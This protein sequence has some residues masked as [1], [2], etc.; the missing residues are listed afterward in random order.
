MVIGARGRRRGSG[1]L[2]SRGVRVASLSSIVVLA[3]A[4]DVGAVGE[5][6]AHEEQVPVAFEALPEPPARG[7]VAFRAWAEQVAAVEGAWLGAL[8]TVELDGDPTLERAARLCGDE[9]TYTLLIEDPDSGRRWRVSESASSRAPACPSTEPVAWEHLDEGLSIVD[10]GPGTHLERWLGLREDR[11]VE[12]ARWEAWAGPMLPELE[13][14]WDLASFAGSLEIETDTERRRLEREGWIL[15]VGSPM[16]PATT[17]VRSGTVRWRGNEDASIAARASSM[18]DG[19]VRLEIQVRDDHPIAA[20][21][22]SL[23]D[24]VDSLE[25][26]W[27]SPGDDLRDPLGENGSARG[28]KL[29]PLRDGR[30]HVA[31]IDE[32]GEPLPQVSGELAQLEV[33]LPIGPRVGVPL[34]LSLVFHDVDGRRGTRPTVIATS[35]FL[36][37]RPAT[38]GWLVQHAE[39]GACPPVGAPV[40]PV[41]PTT[42]LVVRLGE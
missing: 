29:V 36:P 24:G 22:A 9:L 18:D 15:T 35:R 4:A 7:D 14:R 26:W 27:A 39:P 1:A 13:M 42:G 20:P 6:V 25:I 19:R 34:P 28:L 41:G 23:V 8:W 5:P 17:Q 33:I 38:F 2:W 21:D 12:T 11:L 31:W 3:T 37:R 30:L 40:E 32:H 16:E 10:A